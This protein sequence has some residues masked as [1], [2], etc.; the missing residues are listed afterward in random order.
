MW[1]SVVR[2]HA[3]IVPRLE[4]RDRVTFGRFCQISCVGT[5]IVEEDVIAS[6]QVQIGDTYHEYADPTIPSTRQPMSSPEAVR[7]GRGSLLGLG[8]IVL[9]GVTVGEHSYITESTVVVRD[10]PPFSVVTGNPGR[11]VERRDPS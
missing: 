5:I 11:V 8:V 1:L 2:A 3:D 10:V 9:P 4:I 6:D 7:I